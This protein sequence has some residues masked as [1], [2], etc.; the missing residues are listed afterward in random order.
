[1]LVG[2]SGCYESFRVG[3]LAIPTMSQLDSRREKIQRSV[4]V[5][6]TIG[7]RKNDFN[8]ISDERAEFSFIYSLGFEKCEEIWRKFISKP[9]ADE[10]WFRFIPFREICSLRTYRFPHLVDKKLHFWMV[11]K[12]AA[13]ASACETM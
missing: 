4:I 2:P 6:C 3:T 8:N 7:I 11:E 1:M 9:Y 13:L 5:R 10:K 12:A